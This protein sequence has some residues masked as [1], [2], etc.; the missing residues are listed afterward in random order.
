MDERAAMDIKQVR[1]GFYKFRRPIEV[2]LTPLGYT[3]RTYRRLCL[4]GDLER[5]R[6]VPRAM[7]LMHRE[8][9]ALAKRAL[10][11]MP[12]DRCGDAKSILAAIKQDSLVSVVAGQNPDDLL[13]AI[14]QCL[15]QNEMPV[16]ECIVCLTMWGTLFI[17]YH[18]R[19]ADLF[20]LNPHSNGGYNL[21]AFNPFALQGD[22]GGT[23]GLFD[24]S[25]CGD[26]GGMP[27][28]R[29]VSRTCVDAALGDG[30]VMLF[31]VAAR[32]RDDGELLAALFSDENA[33]RGILRL[34]SDTQFFLRPDAVHGKLEF[35][36][37]LLVSVNHHLRT[38]H[39][40]QYTVDEAVFHQARPACRIVSVD[41]SV[42]GDREALDEIAYQ[43]TGHDVAISLPE[44]TD[45]E[46]VEAI[47]RRLG[48][49]V[50]PSA[51]IRRAAVERRP[52]RV[53][54]EAARRRFPQGRS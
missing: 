36:A 34:I 32:R 37:N 16:P 6:H 48:Y 26:E 53:A 8:Y 43:L 13:R 1:T 22:G 4:A 51:P 20:G 28:F 46:T 12:G 44:G 11:R 2:A 45:F 27:M 39:A 21:P 23:Y 24:V 42:S 17:Q 25:A 47:R 5:A 29:S 35:S 19:F 41:A 10:D 49:I 50:L 3:E 38:L 31:A 14:E 40:P 7:A 18:W 54:D 9:V 15:R 30:A 52:Y 33:K